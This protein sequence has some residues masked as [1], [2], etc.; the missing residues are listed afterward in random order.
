MRSLSA[1]FLLFVL[2]SSCKLTPEDTRGTKCFFNVDEAK[3]SANGTTRYQ[4]DYTYKGDS[5]VLI[6]VK[7]RTGVLL[8]DLALKY[9]ASFQL[10]RIVDK[11][12]GKEEV[13]IAY[14]S[15]KRWRKIAF[16]NGVIDS[17]FYSATG[18]LERI[19]EY[20]ATRQT[21]ETFEL[22]FDKGIPNTALGSN[23]KRI[24]RTSLNTESMETTT[25][26]IDFTYASHRDLYNLYNGFINNLL[27]R[28]TPEESFMFTAFSLLP[29]NYNLATVIKHK[30]TLPDNSQVL[31]TDSITYLFTTDF[32]LPFDI[33]LKRG[34]TTLQASW[35]NLCSQF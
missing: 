22:E 32:S 7:D 1:I 4:Y 21:I 2:L 8:K 35:T 9:N 23:I 6:K 5:I 15:D 24:T 20:D 17:A 10:S 30:T 14:S 18:S 27:A 19:K 26:V 16:A 33:K 11:L 34:T 31:S 13:K 3:F 29:T 12:T 28:I 25:E